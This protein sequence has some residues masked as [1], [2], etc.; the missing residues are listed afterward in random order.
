MAVAYS[1]R[2]QRIPT[3]HAPSLTLLTVF[4]W[5]RAMTMVDDSR[6]LQ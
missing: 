6:E 5:D 3:A 1:S 4:G 2:R